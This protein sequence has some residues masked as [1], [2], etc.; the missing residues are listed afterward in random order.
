MLQLQNFKPIHPSLKQIVVSGVSG[1]IGAVG[2]LFAVALYV[3]ETLIRPKKIN[4]FDLYTFSPYELDIPAEAVVF[5][6]LH[7]DHKV[8]A[9]YIP[10]PEPQLPFWYVQDIVL[11]WP[12]LW[13]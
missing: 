6:D 2:I 4:P 3:V 12:I 9:W 11:V 1:V 13:V 8:S 10:T 7:G 5:P